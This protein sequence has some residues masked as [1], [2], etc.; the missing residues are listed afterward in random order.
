MKTEKLSKSISLL[1]H[2]NLCVVNSGTKENPDFVVGGTELLNKELT[3]LFS[4]YVAYV[5]KGTLCKC[6]KEFT[7]YN[8]REGLNVCT[9]CGE[10]KLA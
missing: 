9:L 2:Q 3:K 8:D 1:M 5:P 6:K 10:S 4:L 7:V